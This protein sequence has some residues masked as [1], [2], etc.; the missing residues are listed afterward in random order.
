MGRYSTL[1]RQL[2]ELS[3][4]ID[5]IKPLAIALKKEDMIMPSII[6]VKIRNMNI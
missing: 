6:S 2:G 5:E 1:C 3:N 4:S